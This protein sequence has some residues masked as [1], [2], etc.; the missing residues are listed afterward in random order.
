MTKEFIIALLKER[1]QLS[2]LQNNE[3]NDYTQAD[4][5]EN[6]IKLLFKNVFDSYEVDFM[7]ETLTKFGD[8]PQLL[9]D[10]N[11]NF[12]VSGDSFSQA[13]SGEEK[14]EGVVTVMVEKNQWFPTIRQALFHYMF[15]ES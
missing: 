3:D 2:C 7:L 15:T 6:Q 14:I 8:C 9:Y 5:I 13:V 1:D 12:A 11:G 4:I 10:D